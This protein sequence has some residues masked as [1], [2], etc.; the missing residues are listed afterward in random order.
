MDKPYS[1]S[2]DRNKEPILHILKQEIS[3]SASQLLEIGSGTGQ[4]AAFFAEHLPQLKWWTSDLLEN[5]SAINSWIEDAPNNALGPLEYQAG[6]TSFPK[7][8]FDYVFTANTLHIMSWADSLA[9]I[10]DLQS[11][12]SGSKVLLYGPFNYNGQFSSESNAEFELW[13]KDRNY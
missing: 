13:L 12:K 3:D 8:D 2:C 11:L 5:H 10:S 7:T 1:P 4:H 6:T 9:L